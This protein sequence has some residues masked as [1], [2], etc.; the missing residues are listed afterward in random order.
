[1]VIPEDANAINGEQ[2]RLDCSD[3][4]SRPG[5]HP[6]IQRK[7]G[8]FWKFVRAFTPNLRRKAHTEFTKT[9]RGDSPLE[10]LSSQSMIFLLNIRGNCS[11]FREKAAHMVE[12]LP[13]CYSAFPLKKRII[14]ASLNLVVG[15]VSKDVPKSMCH[16]LRGE[17]SI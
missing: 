1:L 9:V 15:V 7:F 5:S 10:Q 17:M 16:F 11:C 3:S 8:R 12:H 6:N 2:K 13:T 4:F 14:S